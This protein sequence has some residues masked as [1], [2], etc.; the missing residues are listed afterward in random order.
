LEKLVTTALPYANGPIH[1]GHLVE[2]VQADIWVRFQ[3][4]I[5]RQC[6]F[7]CGD[8]AH[9]SAIMLAAEKSGIQPEQ[10]IE[11]I[12]Q[13]HYR[14]FQDFL[15]DYDLYHTTHSDE[16]KQLSCEIYKTL[17][18]SGLIERKRVTQ[19]YDDQ[20]N[21][22]LPDRYVKGTCPKCGS[23]DQYGDSC[24][25]CGAVYTPDQLLNP[26]SVLTQTTPIYKD[27]EHYFF[28]LSKCQDLLE[29]WVGR[30]AL[31]PEVEKKLSEWFDH[32]LKNWDIS[33]DAPY[34]GIEIP[35]APGKYFYVWMDAPIG[36]IAATKHWAN[37]RGLDEKKMWSHDSK[38]DI[39]HFIGKDILYFHGLFW[40]A[41]LH[42]AGY[43]T[44]DH[45][46][47]HGF[48]T[49]NG[50]KMSK[51]RGTYVTARAYLD[52]FDPDYLRYYFAAKLSPTIS[53]I[54][55]NWTEFA[56][57]INAE[58]IGKIINIGSRCTCF[59]HRYFSGVLSDHLSDEALY[60]QI[61]SNE[62]TLLQLYDSRDY[63]QCLRL[64]LQMADQVNQ[65]LDQVKPWAMVKDESVLDQVGPICTL[66]VSVFYSLMGF[67]SPVLPG[68]FER[69]QSFLR[70]E[71][72]NWS[73]FC[74]PLLSQQ[75][76]VFPRL[77]ERVKLSDAS[78][79]DE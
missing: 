40:P 69:V 5:G 23:E 72:S 64:L 62:S 12:R 4:L 77:L 68:T 75:I 41:I 22:F 20:A 74:R 25:Q 38:T 78:F 7:L 71:H 42:H 33:R 2:H 6:L 3:R 49:I 50:K 52:A 14:D 37:S 11:T 24:E 54:D 18:D 70:V 73:D 45:I 55:L 19:A 31:Q 63:N 8:D 15:V 48:L 13:E 27:S 76:D 66:G 56:S 28:A 43:K 58:L 35:D 34:F 51:S 32:G 67:L 65:Y 17:R 1:L 47:A 26:K 53:D 79:I 16:N 61:I 9:G 44:P 21:M 60:Q 39:V 10:W 59:I 46:Y 30:G 29:D 36:Y 57:R